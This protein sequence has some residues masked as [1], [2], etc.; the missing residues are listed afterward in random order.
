V[1]IG[2]GTGLLSLMVAQKNES[3][4][5]I[6]EI[7]EECFEQMKQNIENAAWK[8]RINCI[9]NDIIDFYPDHTYDIIISNPPFHQGQLKSDKSSTNLARHGDD[10]TIEILFKKVIDLLKKDGFFYLLMPVYRDQETIS[11]AETNEMFCIKK[12]FVKQSVHHD[13]FRIMYAFSKTKHSEETIEEIVIKNNQNQYTT[14]FI[15]LLKDY[16]LNL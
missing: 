7:E 14:E 13:P 2:G 6:I 12:A 10:L 1:D 4:I 9:L 5:D 11:M 16:Y 3:K 15:E 8:D